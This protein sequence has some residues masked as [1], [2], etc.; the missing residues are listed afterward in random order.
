MTQIQIAGSIID[1]IENAKKDSKE[2]PAEMELMKLKHELYVLVSNIYKEIPLGKTKGLTKTEIWEVVMDW[3]TNGMCP[4]IL[5]D[6]NGRDLEEI[7]EMNL[8]NLR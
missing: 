3:Y 7:C 2:Y 5:Q 8:D 1:C 4:D 6:E